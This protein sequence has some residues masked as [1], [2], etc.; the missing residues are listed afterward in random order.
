[1]TAQPP[2][3]SSI[4]QLQY[5]QSVGVFT[6][7]ADAQT[8]VDYLADNR[9]PVENLAIVGTDLKS[10]ERVTGRRNWGTVLLSGVQSGVSTGLMVALLM[11]FL[12]PAANVFT[13][14][15]MA[16]AIGIGIGVAFGAVGY[17]MS[18]GRRDFTSVSQTIATKYEVL[19]E[20]KVA[21]Q[22]RDLLRQAPGARAAQ[23]DPRTAPA[24]SQPGVYPDP[25]Q[26]AYPG[27]QYGAQGYPQGAGYPPPAG[28]P[29]QSGYPQS[30][31]QPPQAPWAAP[32]GEPTPPAAPTESEPGRNG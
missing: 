5:P 25:G 2:S 19:S 18:R 29:V 1:M 16:L 10:V 26:Q 14:L 8:A 9:F 31:Q 12:Q 4:F 17:A 22:A 11:W 7:Y 32:A 15:P 28:G 27:A 6:S 30:G 21:G 3:I 13:L 24:P 23:F 20:H